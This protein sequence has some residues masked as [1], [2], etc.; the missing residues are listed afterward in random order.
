MDVAARRLRVATQSDRELADN[1][2]GLH[3]EHMIREARKFKRPTNPAARR[4]FDRGLAMLNKAIS[5]H[6]IFVLKTE[7]DSHRLAAEPL[8]LA[9]SRRLR[10][11]GWEGDLDEMRGASETWS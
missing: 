8:S 2:I 5:D 7:E 9:A 3:M 6:G 4:L 1:A 11:S 10:G